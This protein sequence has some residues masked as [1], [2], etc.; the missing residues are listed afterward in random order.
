VI[1]GRPRAAIFDL[2][3]VLVHS[4]PYHRAAWRALLTEL[5]A[6]PEDG[7]FW[8]LTIGRPV[9]EAL[10][11]LLGRRLSS[12][13]IARYSARKTILYHQFAEGRL[14]QVPG[15]VAFVGSLAAQNVPR[16][17][18]TSASRWSVTAALRDLGLTPHF[19][20][21]VTA[22]D[23]DRG[24][25]DP[26]VYLTAAARLGVEPLACIVFE[27]SVV[28]VEAARRAG[29]RAVGLATAYTE[30]ELTEAGAVRVLAN[31]EGLTWEAI[32]AG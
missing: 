19:P 17:L 7:E 27:D 23:V 11:L 13:E 6:E 29:M 2:D 14:S 21:V 22:D 4:G 10:P 1:S 3:G 5:G 28:G 26:E 30:A 20:V 24:K 9:E 8:R 32:A 16:G 18:A 12:S 25:P 15:A 31:F